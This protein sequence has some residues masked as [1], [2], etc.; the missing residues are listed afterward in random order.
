MEKQPAYFNPFIGAAKGKELRLFI[1]TNAGV[2]K[3]LPSIIQKCRVV[4]NDQLNTVEEAP[5]IADRLTLL[6][7]LID[8]RFRGCEVL[9]GAVRQL[10]QGIGATFAVSYFGEPVNI[11]R[12][13]RGSCQT[14]ALRVDVISNTE[15]SYKLTT[16]RAQA[17][18]GIHLLFA[19][20]TVDLN[21]KGQIEN[22][23]L[24]GVMVKLNNDG[25]CTGFEIKFQGPGLNAPR[26]TFQFNGRFQEEI[27][28]L[29]DGLSKLSFLKA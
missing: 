24:D 13:Y 9:T 2:R 17:I 23:D 5:E 12:L 28:D 25:T 18:S 4:V 27:R 3:L 29:H 10:D 14:L 20:G 21:K 15:L 6:Q 19:C 26:T 22:E 7:S 11:R 1:G 8:R 16:A